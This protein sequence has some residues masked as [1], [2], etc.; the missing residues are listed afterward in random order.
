MSAPNIQ[1][2]FNQFY[3]KD[4]NHALQSEGFLT[5]GMTTDTD[6]VVGN[7]VFW[8][9]MGAALTTEHPVSISPVGL[10]N[11]A[12]SRVSA[13]IGDWDADAEFKTRDQN[14]ISAN[15][16]VA[17][18]MAGKRAIGRRYDDI[19][20]DSIVAST[21]G[22]VG[23]AGGGDTITLAMTQTAVAQIAG[24]QGSMTENFVALP[25]IVMQRFLNV[26]AFASSD[27]VGDM[28]LMKKLG[29]RTWNG[30]TYF[31]MEDSF[32][33]SRAPVANNID[34]YVWNKACI[35]RVTQEL[36]GARLDYMPREKAWHIGQSISG[37]A[38]VI[39]PGGVR[40]V[41]GLM[42]TAV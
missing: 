18:T 32:F 27:F 8:H 37:C 30:A 39:L 4:V 22:V 12:V 3:T 17:L 42:P 13:T 11:S 7:Q 5:K 33:T 19:V 34:L 1:A 14:K 36:T 2:W 10:M 24:A 38:A 29:A 41:R 26:P 20:L 28:P 21:A 9:V 15:L 23:A 35:G 40:R 6:E 31:P 25:F 16:Q